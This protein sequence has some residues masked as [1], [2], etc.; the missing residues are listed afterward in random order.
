MMM[1]FRILLS[2]NER[3]F[4]NLFRKGNPFTCSPRFFQSTTH[5]LEI[6]E[7]TQALYS[8]LSAKTQYEFLDRDVSNLKLVSDTELSTSVEFKEFLNILASTNDSHGEDKLSEFQHVFSEKFTQWTKVSQLRVGFLMYLDQRISSHIYLDKVIRHL[9]S[10]NPFNAS[11]H[12]L[13][14]LLLLIYFKRDVSVDSLSEFMDLSLLQASLSS[15]I[16]AGKFTQEEVCAV[17][18]SL[19]RISDFKVNHKPFRAELYK[20]LDKFTPSGDTK[21]DDFFIMTL[22]TILS[23]G[24]LVCFD[25]TEMVMTMLRSI[26]KYVDKLGLAISIRLLSF[27]LTLG[28]SNKII[29]ERVL[30]RIQTSLDQC[31]TRD[32]LS[33]CNYF[34]KQTEDNVSM[35]NSLVNH[36]EGCMEHFET[37][38]ELADILDCFHYLSHKSNYSGK[39]N[40]LIF[41]ALKHVETSDNP[42]NTREIGQNIVTFLFS[43]LKPEMVNN[44]KETSAL[45]QDRNLSDRFTRI[46][47]FLYNSWEVESGQK[48]GKVDPVFLQ[49]LTN[50][51]HKR[52]PIELYSPQLDIKD[53]EH[54][55]KHLVNVYRAMVKFMGNEQHVKPTRLL[56]HFEQPDIVF[57]NIGGMSMT[58]PKYLTDP[59]CLGVRRA[60]PGDWWV[61]VLAARK[62]L[63]AENRVIGQEALKVKQLS[64]LGYNPVVIP[65][66]KISHGS[67]MRTLTEVLKTTDV[68]LPNLDDGT[69]VRHRGW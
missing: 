27:P 39:F 37:V 3:Q 19:K 58:V 33:L 12:D 40:D 45:L 54:R 32:L 67:L 17:C 65:L 47:S 18:L 69:E 11:P 1:N 5:H 15:H 9:G 61:L 35:M 49:N 6:N 25:N 13:V 34:S 62:H 60:P 24:N 2:F 29:E 28:V 31:S 22:L 57:G 59:D 42:L 51:F 20:Q 66:S 43:K 52:L 10:D 46:P 14:A 64:K 21:L 63:D 41:D 36:L 8:K 56:P 7:Y 23:K 48:I 30:A 4:G 53:L 68:D 26:S 38:E 55:N 16:R 44:V 50:S